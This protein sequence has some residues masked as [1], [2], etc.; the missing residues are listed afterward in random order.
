[1]EEYLYKLKH[2]RSHAIDSSCLF[3]FGKISI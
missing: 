3:F 2:A 1:M